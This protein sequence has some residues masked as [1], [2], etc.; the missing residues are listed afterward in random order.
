M[1]DTVSRSMTALHWLSEEN[2]PQLTRWLA[3]V[4]RPG[5][6]FADYDTMELS[7]DVPRLRHAAQGLRTRLRDDALDE[8]NAE[9]WDQWWNALRFEPALAADFEERERRFA[10]RQTASG[11]L[12]LD[13]LR[14][15]LLEAGFAEAAALGQVA[16]RHLL[17]AIR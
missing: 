5:G 7:P 8:P 6:V 10:F 3:T 11:G 12:S 2:V 15:A 9:T 16:D 1:T 17:V 4:L 13:S 14:T